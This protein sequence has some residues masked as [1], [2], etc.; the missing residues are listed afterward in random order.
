MHSLSEAG[1]CGNACYKTSE[2]QVAR[3]PLAEVGERWREYSFNEE[4]YRDYLVYF[5]SRRGVEFSILF[6]QRA[7]TAILRQSP[8]VRSLLQ[9][10]FFDKNFKICQHI[11]NHMIRFRFSQQNTF[12]LFITLCVVAVISGFIV[13]PGA[14]NT[15]SAFFSNKFKIELG[16]IVKPFQLGLDLQGGTHLVYSADV[17][18]VKGI[19]PKEALDSVQ[20]V[21]E[22]RVNLFGVGEPVVQI[23]QSGGD[24][25]LIVELAGV[26]D[27]KQAIQLI[28]E[29]PYLDFRVAGPKG[30][31]DD[32]STYVATNLNGSY[33]QKA[34][35]DFDQ[36]TGHAQ[37]TLEFNSQGAKL[38]EDLTRQ[39]LQKRVGIFLDGF[40]ISAPVVQT[41]I[42][43]GKAVITGNFS[44]DDAKTLARRLNAG[45][46]PVPIKLISQQ[47]IGASLGQDSLSRVINAALWGFILL[48][49]FM[50]GY[51]R[52]PGLLGIIALLMYTAFILAIYKLIP[53]TLTLAGIAGFILSL[54]IAID[55]NIL[56]FERIKDELKAGRN[57]EGAISEGFLRAW[58]S[59]RDSNITD[60]ISAA[61]LYL[62]SSSFIQ[63]F[64]FTLLIGIIVSMFTAVFVSRLMLEISARSKLKNFAWIWRAG[65]K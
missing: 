5:P 30:K 23:A 24:W 14:F 34:N 64:A 37:V 54:G 51:Y 61:I 13:Y 55:A 36:L 59:V 65:I 25:R 43:G 1:G 60:M 28:G 56:I 57:L 46:L 41:V 48:T 19:S 45:A 38:F 29:T 15:I 26:K 17:S 31:P 7:M 16:K 2:L 20:S 11:V 22:R 47:T 35:V 9:G 21:I 40:P 53:V 10:F 42:S 58:S 8:V 27:V 50:V 12:W 49:I 4:R 32:L 33:L 6:S 63:G 39:N 18:Q 52:F 44:L 62:I 3:Q